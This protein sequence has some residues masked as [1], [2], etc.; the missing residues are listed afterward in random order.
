MSRKSGLNH[1]SSS[2]PKK[3]Y[4]AGVSRE[5]CEKAVKL[6]TELG[7]SVA[8]VARQLGCSTAAVHR[9]QAAATPPDPVVKNVLNRD[10]TA[11]QPNE[12]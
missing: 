4:S 8:E 11:A 2:K 1:K 9:W 12:K 3:S 6:I 10:F 5:V 7:Y